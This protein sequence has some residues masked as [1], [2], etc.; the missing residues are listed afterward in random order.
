MADVARGWEL[1]GLADWQGA[2][3]AFQSALD[4]APGDPDALDGLGQRPGGW[5]SAMRPSSYRREAFAGYRRAGV[6]PGR[7]AAGHLPGG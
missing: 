3:D 7:R 2:R 5:A 4:A 1:F 6:E